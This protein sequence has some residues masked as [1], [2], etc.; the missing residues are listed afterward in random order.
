MSNADAQLLAPP[1]S[2]NQAFVKLDQKFDSHEHC[3]IRII[4]GVP[5]TCDH[6][7]DDKLN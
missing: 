5:K 2:H 1:R 3:E 4:H 6:V 7:Y